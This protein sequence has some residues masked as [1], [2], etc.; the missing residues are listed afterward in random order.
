MFE[1]N[2]TDTVEQQGV[3]VEITLADGTVE[4][5]RLLISLGRSLVEVLNGAGGFI[6]F[7]PWGGERLYLS[8]ASLRGIKLVQVPKTTSLK[9]RL[10]TLDAFD[11]HGV[12]GVAAG[13]TLNEIKAAWHRLSMAY[14]ADRYASANLPSEVTDYLSAMSRRINAAYAALEAPALLSRKAAAM[15]EPPVYTSRPRA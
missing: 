3:P 10:D 6:E 4:A 7:E 11:P 14:H 1:R 13:A 5:G 12:L 9:S 2:R 15:R 8:K